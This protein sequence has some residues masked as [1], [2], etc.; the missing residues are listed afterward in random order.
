MKKSLKL[1]ISLVLCLAVV[2][3][4]VS[5]GNVKELINGYINDWTESGSK[6][7]ERYPKDDPYLLIVT[8]DGYTGG[9]SN[10]QWVHDETGFYWLETYDEVLEAVE[11]L[12]SHGSTI[13]PNIGFDC[14]GEQLMDVK[15]C[16]MFPKKNAEPLEEGKNFFDRK[17]DGGTFCWYGF[18]EEISIE[19]LT[20]EIVD[21]LD[22]V[23]IDGGSSRTVDFGVVE[24]IDDVS[25]VSFYCGEGD[26]DRFIG[27]SHPL[28]YRGE[29]FATLKFKDTV[30]H[31]ADYRKFLN[32]FVVIE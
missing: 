1:V 24:K 11:L 29:H 21:Y 23:Y 19:E 10:F 22:T 5:C 13:D 15:Y 9:F 25:Y 2:L 6:E 20:H 3:S 28:Y 26:S 16:F 27:K 14:E 18:F 30:I 4:F 31:P 32:T 8:K 17:I 7:D 12:K